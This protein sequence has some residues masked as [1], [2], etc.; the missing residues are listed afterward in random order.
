MLKH[1]VHFKFETNVLPTLR[2]AAILYMRATLLASAATL[3][4]SR[5]LEGGWDDGLTYIHA[6]QGFMVMAGCYHSLL[7]EDSWHGKT[8]RATSPRRGT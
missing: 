6:G 2:Q 3:A 7:K 4:S 1:V 8:P 5:Q